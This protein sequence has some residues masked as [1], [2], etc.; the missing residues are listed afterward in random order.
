VDNIL[1]QFEEISCVD[2]Y[3]VWVRGCDV[4]AVTTDAYRSTDCTMIHMRNG[5]A[6]LVAGTPIQT[7][8]KLELDYN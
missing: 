1:T 4:I 7:M 8:R 2:T 6:F 5:A 3:P